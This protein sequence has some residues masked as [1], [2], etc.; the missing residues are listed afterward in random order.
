M[1]IDG[2]NSDHPSSCF[3]PEQTK[4]MPACRRAIRNRRGHGQFDLCTGSGS[5]PNIQLAADLLGAFT[6]AGQAEV[7][8]TPLFQNFAWNAHPVVPNAQAENPLSIGNFS[9]YMMGPGVAES[10]SQSLSSNAVKLVSN[11]R[12]QVSYWAFHH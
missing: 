7:T 11:D 3:L 2:Q 9:F 12:V 10:V 8:G 1:V 4:K 5:T 6:H